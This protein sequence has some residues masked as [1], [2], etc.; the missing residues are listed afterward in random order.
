VHTT[1]NIGIKFSSSNPTGRIK[2][3]QFKAISTVTGGQL[4]EKS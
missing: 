4:K 3:E 1:T 2:L